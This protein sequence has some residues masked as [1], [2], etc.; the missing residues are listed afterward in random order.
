[1][2]LLDLAYWHVSNQLLGDQEVGWSKRTSDGMVCLT[3]CGL[4]VHQIGTGLLSWGFQ[5]S[6]R[7]STEA[8]KTSWGLGSE[9][10]IVFGFC[11]FLQSKKVMQTVQ[12]REEEKQPSF[13]DGS[14][15]DKVVL[16]GQREGYSYG[17]VYKYLIRGYIVKAPRKGWV[18]RIIKSSNQA[19]QALL[20]HDFT[21]CPPLVCC[22]SNPAVSPKHEK[23]ILLCYVF[24]WQLRILFYPFMGA[25]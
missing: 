4:I 11:Y 15:L 19:G 6:K 10:H 18:W 8:C 1:M 21:P 13:P 20:S 24:H 2:I 16:W 25:N 7:N 22:C 17:Q 5:R 3:L 12:P 14:G 9:M 23:I